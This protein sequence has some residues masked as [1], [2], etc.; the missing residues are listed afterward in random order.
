MDSQKS[1]VVGISVDEGINTQIIQK[2]YEIAAW[3]TSYPSTI[4]RNPEILE[5]L[6]RFEKRLAKFCYSPLSLFP[7]SFLCSDSSDSINKLRKLGVWRKS[8]TNPPQ[9]KKTYYKVNRLESNETN[10]WHNVPHEKLYVRKKRQEDAKN[11][12]K[13]HYKVIPSS[14]FFRNESHV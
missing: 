5:K 14:D 7:K 1:Y 4:A 3:E 8:D 6:K 2:P 12:N 11:G 13:L 9:L 10:T